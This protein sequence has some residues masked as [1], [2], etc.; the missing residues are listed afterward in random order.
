MNVAVSFHE[1]AESELNEAADYYESHVTGL[2]L[3]F[4][5]EVERSI[6]LIRQNP[7]SFPPI[8]KVV[9]CKTLRRFPYSLIYSFVDDSIRILAIANQKRRPLYWRSRK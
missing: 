2:G 9:R 8:L 1:L 6:N 3:A 7:A 4:I 5:T